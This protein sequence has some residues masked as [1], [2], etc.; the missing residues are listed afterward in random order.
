MNIGEDLLDLLRVGSWVRIA[1]QGPSTP[2]RVVSNAMVIM[3]MT[4]STGFSAWTAQ[5]NT[6]NTP[7]NFD[8]TLIGFLALLASLSLGAATMFTLALYLS[9]MDSSYRT[10]LS[11]KETKL[12]GHAADHYKK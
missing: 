6:E 3:R 11:L 1:I 8:S 2:Q 9:I 5:Q 4:L 12:N 7:N 10:I